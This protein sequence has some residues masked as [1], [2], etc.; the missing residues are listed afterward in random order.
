MEHYKC[1]VPGCNVKRYQID[2]KQITIQF[3]NNEVYQY[4]YT[5]AGKKHIETMKLLAQ[6]GWG[7]DTYIDQ[8]VKQ[9]YARQ[10]V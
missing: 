3:N 2:S 4:T 10:L 6:A 8:V 5:S 1:I 9:G 7:L